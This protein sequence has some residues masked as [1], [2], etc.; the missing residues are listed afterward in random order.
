MNRDEL[1]LRHLHS[2][3]FN[4]NYDEGYDDDY[5]GST[6][7]AKL[8]RMQRFLRISDYLLDDEPCDDDFIDRFNGYELSWP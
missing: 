5:R 2:D 6:G 1:Q 3:F 4:S 7:F 8:Q